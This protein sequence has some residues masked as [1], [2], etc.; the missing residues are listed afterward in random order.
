MN[1]PYL[2]LYLVR[3]FSRPLTRPD[4][5]TCKTHESQIIYNHVHE[6]RERHLRVIHFAGRADAFNMKK[7]KNMEYE[8]MEWT[9]YGRLLVL[10]Q[11]Q[12]QPGWRHAMPMPNAPPLLINLTNGPGWYLQR[13]RWF[14]S[15]F[16]N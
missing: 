4:W 15:P 12:K 7:Y 10:K 1:I 6:L 13:M 5:R 11:N 3:E 8:I 16:Y 9:H 14:M 2:A